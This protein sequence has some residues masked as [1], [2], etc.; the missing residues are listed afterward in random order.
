MNISNVI[1]R[2]LE[3][4]PSLLESHSVDGAPFYFTYMRYVFTLPTSISQDTLRSSGVVKVPVNSRHEYV[5]YVVQHHTVQ[6]NTWPCKWSLNFKAQNGKLTRWHV[7]TLTHTHNPH[8]PAPS[9]SRPV[10]C[11][12]IILVYRVH[13]ATTCHFRHLHNQRWTG[14]L[15][16]S[17]YLRGLRGKTT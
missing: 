16:L 14:K 12:N 9:L 10:F 3:N 17:V 15:V 8:T 1:H 13:H 2:D 11:N 6:Y 7:D 5:V 4:K